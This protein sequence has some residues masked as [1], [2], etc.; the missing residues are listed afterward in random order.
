MTFFLSILSCNSITF[1]I[2]TYMMRLKTNHNI[3][4]RNTPFNQFF[5]Y[6]QVGT[7]VLQPNTAI[8]FYIQNGFLL[9]FA[10]LLSGYQKS[11]LLDQSFFLMI[12]SYSTRFI[13]IASRMTIHNRT[14][15]IQILFGY[16]KE[17]IVPLRLFLKK[18]H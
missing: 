1:H 5:P 14:K 6:T 13:F 8:C 12:A 10:Y 16:M 7:I 17:V 4:L 9:L 3:V 15:N 11:M 18:K 2:D